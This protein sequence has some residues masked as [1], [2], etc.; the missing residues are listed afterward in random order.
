MTPSQTGVQDT[1]SCD[2][3][4]VLGILEK[5]DKAPGALISILGDIQNKYR[6][7]PADALKLAS[8]H[9]GCS[10]VDVYAAA[11]FYHAFSLTPRGKHIVQVCMG[12]ACH[13]RG[14]PSVAEEFE[15]L[16]GIAPGETTPDKEFTFETRNCLGACA[17]GPVV[18]I[19]G[20]YFSK[21]RRP[22]VRQLIEGTL[23]GFDE[24]DPG[25][26]IRFFPIELSCPKCSASLMDPSVQLDGHPSILLNTSHDGNE[27]C[28]RLSSLYGSDKCSCDISVPDGEQTQF[29]CPHCGEDMTTESD[30]C[31]ICGAVGL[32]M[33]VRGGGRLEICTRRG[34]HYHMLHLT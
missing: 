34:C 24:E 14:A 19:D 5:H 10:L 23:H 12:T 29:L 1:G 22:Q 8:D 21:V 20:R 4:E 11:T 17:L 30:P 28:V 3:A 31:P 13:V 25:Q 16:L 26:D 2:P 18:V 32:C 9:C 15:K 6:Y 7:L 33:D 27:G